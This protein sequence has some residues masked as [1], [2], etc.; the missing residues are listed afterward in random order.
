VEADGLYADPDLVQFYDIE[1][2]W[3][4]DLDYCRSLADGC[5]SVLDLG[6]GTDL[7][8]ATLAQRA[9]CTVVGVDPAAAMLGIAAK[10]PGGER[11]EWQLGDARTIRLDRRF[12][13]VVL[14][15]HAFQ[16]FLTDEDRAAALRTI[17]D[18]LTPSGR[19]IFDSRNPA[20]RSWMNW[21][22]AVSL[23]YIEHPTLGRVRACNDASHD[24][25]TS[26][27]TYGT[28]YKPM[29][30]DRLHSSRSQ[31]A[32]PSQEKLSAQIAAAG[33]VVRQWLGDWLG[34]PYCSTSPEIIPIGA[35]PRLVTAG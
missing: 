22:P 28:H 29:A 4:Q 17:A 26:V 23:R 21:T 19:F 32:F 24:P 1:N 10:R 7:F 25:I 5:S 3:A 8:A 16:V 9:E 31:I 20:G 13:L 12:D 6:C 27:V 35:L 15:G 33:L 34:S 30:N 11:V 18:H 2:G 14:T